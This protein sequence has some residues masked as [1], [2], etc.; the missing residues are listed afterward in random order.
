MLNPHSLKN[1]FTD[2]IRS[3]ETDVI[4]GRVAFTFDEYVIV[5]DST[6]NNELFKYG[7]NAL[8]VHF[9]SA[10]EIVLI[11]T[12][13]IKLISL[14]HHGIIHTTIPIDFPTDYSVFSQ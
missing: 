10:N 5:T 14:E 7:C 3:L 8:G 9:R 2:E 13:T 6:L 11:D 1:A 12:H 4:S